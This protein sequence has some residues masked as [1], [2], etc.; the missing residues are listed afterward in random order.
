MIRIS[1]EVGSDAASFTMTVLEESIIG[2]IT[3]AQ[4]KY[5]GERVRAV[6]PIEPEEFFVGDAKFVGAARSDRASEE[7]DA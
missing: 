2:A 7:E 5:P 4:E 3:T 1:V 6:F